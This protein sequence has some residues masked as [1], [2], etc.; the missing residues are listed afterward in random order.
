M[1]DLRILIADNSSLYK[2]M[3]PDAIK[4]ADKKASVTCVATSGEASGMV[5]RQ[6]YDIIV[7]DAEIPGDGALELIQ[8]IKKDIPKAYIMVTARPSA[9]NDKLFEDALS[10]GAAECMVKPIY[11]SYGDNFNIIKARMQVVIEHARDARAKKDDNAADG[12]VKNAV[13]EDEFRPEIVLIAA[14]TGGPF[15]LES[16]IPMMRED[17][18]VPVLIVQHMPANITENLAQNLDSKSRIKVKVAEHREDMTAGTVY[19]APGGT[20][21][22]L[23]AK[24]KIRLDD[25]P[26]IHGVRPSADAL[27]ES[28]AEHFTGS[29]VLVIVLTGM[30]SDGKEGIEF[31]KKR[32]KCFCLTQSE[33]T[34]VVY[35]MPRAVEEEGLADKVLDLEDILPE[36]ESLK[37]I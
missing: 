29:G 21:M 8:A 5:E 6:D 22:K 14:S 25:S 27:F 9:G 11:D 37:W 28:V 10:K 15:A 3:F 33:R 26:P 18:P 2:K 17:F 1:E 13:K 16:I 24:S 7:I 31:L 32:K 34:C 12:P 20:H 23:G 36:I 30:G 35:G 4:E 19:L